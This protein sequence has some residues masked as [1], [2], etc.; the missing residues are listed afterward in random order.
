MRSSLPWYKRFLNENTSDM[1]NTFDKH[2]RY[3]IYTSKFYKSDK[4]LVC[5]LQQGLS[6]QTCDL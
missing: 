1:E 5:K 3:Q 4:Y 6:I 2:I